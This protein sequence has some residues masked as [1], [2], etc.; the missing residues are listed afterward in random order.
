MLIGLTMRITE[1]TSYVEYRDSI[2]HDWINYLSNYGISPILLPNYSADIQS[3]MASISLS[4]II[5]SG[6]DS[7]ID[8]PTN[9]TENIYH[10]RDISELSILENGIRMGLPILGTCRGLQIINKFFKGAITS[11]IRKSKDHPV[12]SN[13]NIN[14]LT[15]PIIPEFSDSEV[16]VNSYHDD[17]ICM[18]D[19]SKCLK[20]FATWENTLVE[21]FYHPN[22][23][24]LG[25]Q[26]HPERTT[27][28]NGL[29]EALFNYWIELCNS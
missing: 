21:G 16:S 2:S 8:N 14:I 13:H 4:G 28:S 20:P 11:N 24:I 1:N 25:I 27:S 7:I 17:G 23:P 29:D 6:G 22:L 18:D 9:H 15:N 3:F 10:Q 12:A 19:L 5:I 26:W